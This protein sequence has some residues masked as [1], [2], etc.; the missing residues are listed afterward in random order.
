M[1]E[2]LG[3]QS[4]LFEER[5]MTTAIISLGDTRAARRAASSVGPRSGS[6]GR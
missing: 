2:G 6:G 5:E 4:Y 1:W 3:A